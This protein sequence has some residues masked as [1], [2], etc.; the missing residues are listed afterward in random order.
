MAEAIPFHLHSL[1][2][3]LQIG[4]LG[5]E[6]HSDVSPPPLPGK[7]PSLSPPLLL[8]ASFPGP[9]FLK[10]AAYEARA[11]SASLGFLGTKVQ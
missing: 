2:G 7:P 8:A 6:K 1:M 11:L 10:A 5:G 9:L 4:Q 3:N